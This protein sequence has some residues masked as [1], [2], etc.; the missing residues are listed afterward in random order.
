MS[1]SSVHVTRDLWPCPTPARAS[2]VE[3]G[4][5][6]TRRKEMM[7]MPGILVGIDGSEQSRQALKWAV[8]EAG[9][10][11]VPLR[12]LTIHQIVAG[13]AGGGVMYPGDH[14]L[15]EDT[16]K[17]AQRETDEVLDAIEEESRP[18]AVT[19]TA[20]GGLPGE[21]LLHAAEDADMV[22]VGARGAGGFKRLLV[23]SV[24]SQLVHHAHCPIVIVPSYER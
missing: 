8:A 6:G 18:P 1:G 7:K 19:V 12:V 3:D 4:K 15:V 14:T 22:V 13:Y 17:A 21:E 16:R 23:G 20:T 10:W 2:S 24:A 5:T 11:R 9:T